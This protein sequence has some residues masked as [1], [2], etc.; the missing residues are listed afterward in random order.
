M[1]ISLSRRFHSLH[2][3]IHLILVA[4]KKSATI[5]GEKCHY[6]LWK[7]PLFNTNYNVKKM[8]N[9]YNKHRFIS[10]KELARLAGVSERTFCRYI[11]SR[12]HILE[13][14]G[15]LPNARLLPPQA[16][17]YVC[18]D[19]CIDLPEYLQDKEVIKK[20]PV[21]RNLVKNYKAQPSLMAGGYGWQRS[22][23]TTDS[24][25]YTDWL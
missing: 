6:S 14:M 1:I 4:P 3:F 13:A 18:E 9:Y 7:E 16:V 10:K 25:R 2:G 11:A 22:H 21:Y 24:F 19:Y 12:R 8:I 23:M 15:V 20:S 5:Q 17:K